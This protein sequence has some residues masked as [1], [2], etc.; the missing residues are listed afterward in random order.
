MTCMGVH[1]IDAISGRLPAVKWHICYKIPGFKPVI[2]LTLWIIIKTKANFPSPAQQRN[3]KVIMIIIL[4]HFLFTRRMYKIRIP[5][6]MQAYHSIIR[7]SFSADEM[8][9]ENKKN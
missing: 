1:K 5:L 4:N 7:G 9:L 2:F 8:S 3:F 6:I